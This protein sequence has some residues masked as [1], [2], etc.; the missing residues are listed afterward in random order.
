MPTFEERINTDV[1]TD[2]LSEVVGD[3]LIRNEVG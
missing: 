1:M 3:K 2:V